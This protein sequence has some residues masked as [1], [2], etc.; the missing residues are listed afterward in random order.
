MVLVL[1]VL[2]DEALYFSNFRE[3]IDECFKVME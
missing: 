1:C 3:N 2:S